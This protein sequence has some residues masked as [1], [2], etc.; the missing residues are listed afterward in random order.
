MSLPFTPYCTDEDVAV[1]ARGDY[2]TL[3]PPDSILAQGVDGSITGGAWVLTSATVNFATQ[4]VAKGNVLAL[5]GPQPAFTKSG[6][7]FA[8]DSVSGMSVT[9]R[10]YGMDPGVGAPP[11]SGSVSGVV[12]SVPTFGPAIAS[13]CLD[14]NQMFGLDPNVALRAPGLVYDPANMLGQYCVL[15]LLHRRYTDETRA[16]RGDYKTNPPHSGEVSERFPVARDE[17]DQS[18]G[19]ATQSSRSPRLRDSCGQSPALGV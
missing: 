13:A 9:L 10:R 16:D 1:R 18:P 11:S 7:L 17:R 6:Q 8:V 12:F 15:V 2:L 4:G 5:S 14:A 3:C 19:A